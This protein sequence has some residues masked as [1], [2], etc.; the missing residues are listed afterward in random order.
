MVFALSLRQRMGNMHGWGGPMS[1]DWHD[2]QLTL[3]H[4]ILNRMRSF[5]MI[6]VLPSFAGHV[7]DAIKRLFPSANISHMDNW[8]NFDKQYCWQVY[9]SVN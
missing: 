9:L 5:G 4:K 3:Q 2:Q 8:G 1:D 7:P 6:P